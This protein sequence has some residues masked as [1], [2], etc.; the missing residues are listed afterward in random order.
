M[1]APIIGAAAISA[2]SSLLGGL[3]NSRAA[4][5]ANAAN[6]AAIAAQNEY[7]SPVQ[8][9]ARAE[10]GGFNPLLFVGPGVGLQNGIAPYM[11]SSM[12]D[13]IA[14]AGLAIAGGLADQAQHDAYTTALEQQNQD[15]RKAVQT[16]TLRPEV[17]G[18]YG[19]AQPVRVPGSPVTA[20]SGVQLDGTYA[21][22]LAFGDVPPASMATPYITRSGE[23]LA[24]QEGADL[25]DS[26]T[27][28]P[29]NAIGNLQQEGTIDKG[30]VDRLFENAEDLMT[31]TARPVLKAAKGLAGG[32]V[33]ANEKL[34]GRRP[35]VTLPGARTHVGFPKYGA[36]AYNPWR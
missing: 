2:G 11:A 36:D 7:N 28:I 34:E 10:E 5:R 27:A 17:P 18:I 4:R 29:M 15:L 25:E 13:S 6:A 20:Q 1:V 26:L 21:G 32:L 22:A 3:F 9:R 14:N 24:F 8:I 33:A 16:A 30:Y 35:L 12:G 19:T 23:V 31:W